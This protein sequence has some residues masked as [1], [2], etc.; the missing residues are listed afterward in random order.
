M[1]LLRFNTFF[2][3]ILFILFIFFYTNLFTI[4]SAFLHLVLSSV[5]VFVLYQGLYVNKFC[6]AFKA[7]LIENKVYKQTKNTTSYIHT[8]TH[9]QCSFSY[10]TYTCSNLIRL[11]STK[12]FVIDLIQLVEL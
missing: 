3:T 9:I 8:L 4:I 10:N 12:C 7:T 2:N 1:F 11:K 6:K 5:S